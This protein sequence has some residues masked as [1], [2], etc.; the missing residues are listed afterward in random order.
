MRKIKYLLVLCLAVFFTGC[1]YTGTPVEYAN[2]CNQANDKKMVEVVGFLDNNGS[3]V[4]S[5]TSGPMTCPISFKDK[6]ETK[7]YFN[8]D[9]WLGNKASEVE[10][11]EGKGLRIRDNKGEFI[12]RTDK[13]KLTGEVTAYSNPTGDPKYACYISTYKIEKAQ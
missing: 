9:I 3:A 10:N 7:E 12:E 2:V 8:A 11:V 13:V 6:L 4:C 5:N 1:N